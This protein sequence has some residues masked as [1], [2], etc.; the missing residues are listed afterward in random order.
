MERRCGPSRLSDYESNNRVSA[1]NS[2][3][4]APGAG[5]WLHPSPRAT[6]RASQLL[7]S[8]GMIGAIEGRRLGRL[9][10]PAPFMALHDPPCPVSLRAPACG[11]NPMNQV[12]SPARSFSATVRRSPARARSLAGACSAAPTS[13]RPTLPEAVP[14]VVSRCFRLAT[15][16]SPIPQTGTR[17]RG[18]QVFV[19]ACCEVD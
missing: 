10:G 3:T 11:C 8:S 13:E 14:D 12:V 4:C 6:R 18:S 9:V 7:L 2:S 5:H 17:D 16:V 15:R 1:V 19:R